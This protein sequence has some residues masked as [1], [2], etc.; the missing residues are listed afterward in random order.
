LKFHK[1][2]LSLVLALKRD[3]HRG[4]HA[5]NLLIKMRMNSSPLPAAAQPSTTK[6]LVFFVSFFLNIVCTKGLVIT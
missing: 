3:D 6:A 2:K 5:K 4:G 1:R